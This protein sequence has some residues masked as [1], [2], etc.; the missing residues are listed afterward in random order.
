MGCGHQH[1]CPGGSVKADQEKLAGESALW[2]HILQLETDHSGRGEGEKRK[3][4]KNLCMLQDHPL[5]AHHIPP[6]TFIFMSVLMKG[7]KWKCFH[8]NLKPALRDVRGLHGIQS[9]SFTRYEREKRKIQRR[10]GSS[11]NLL[12][13]KRAFVQHKTPAKVGRVR[14]EYKR[15]CEQRDCG[16]SASSS[17]QGQLWGCGTAGV[18]WEM[19]PGRER[20][21]EML[22]PAG[23]GM[24]GAHQQP[25]DVGSLQ[26]TEPG[27]LPGDV[28]HSVA[29]IPSP[30]MGQCFGHG[31]ALMHSAHRALLTPCL[32]NKFPS[33]ILTKT[34]VAWGQN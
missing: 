27:W 9:A 10:G 26:H 14:R 32:P 8:A 13:T 23:D 4:K 20:W 2:M 5:P 31:N 1:S 18:C 22:S 3:E 7:T 29:C 24:V 11:R 21:W 6:T 33:K 28:E 30:V 15:G 19:P 25:W 17:R 34:W 12:S 16:R